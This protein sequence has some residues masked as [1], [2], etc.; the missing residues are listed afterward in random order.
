MAVIVTEQ[1]NQGEDAAD[2]VVV[3]YEP[4]EVLVDLERAM[5]SSTLIY[6]DAGSNVVVDSTVW[7]MP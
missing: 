4:L 7:G 6:P 5:T 2:L 1:A 3:D